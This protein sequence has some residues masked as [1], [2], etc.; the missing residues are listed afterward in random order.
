VRLP[1][2]TVVFGALILGVI[3]ELLR[4]RR[5]REK[6]AF[7]WLFTGSL[8]I[9][10]A[11]FPGGLDRVAGYLGVASGVS[12]VLFLAVVFL[13][14]IAIHLSWE[15]S[16]LEEET[17]SIS[18]EIALLRLELERCRPDASAPREPTHDDP[19]DRSP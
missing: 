3:V 1:I 17:R 16:Q 4:R 13:L 19:T 5:L 2:T 6:Y 8:V 12:L 10:L 11:V 14:V 7:I 15:V 9:V 18:E